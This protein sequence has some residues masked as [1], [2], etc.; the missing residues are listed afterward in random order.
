MSRPLGYH[1]RL[2]SKATECFRC[3]Q[4]QHRVR[5]D[6][7]PWQEI[8]QIGL[9]HHRPAADIERKKPQSLPKNLAKLLAAVLLR[10]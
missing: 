9:E 5:V 1:Y 8:D 4:H 2:S 3:R 10:A 6:G 7:I